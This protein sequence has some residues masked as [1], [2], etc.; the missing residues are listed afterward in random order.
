MHYSEAAFLEAVDENHELFAKQV[1][2]VRLEIDVLEVVIQQHQLGEQLGRV[3]SEQQLAGAL[4]D[5]DLRTR[6]QVVQDGYDDVL[7]KLQ[8]HF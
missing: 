1:K 5:A 6:E 4:V 7:V 2:D 3:L 8:V